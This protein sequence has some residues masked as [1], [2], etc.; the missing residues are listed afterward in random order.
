MFAL[1]AIHHVAILTDSAS[2]VTCK[3]FYTRILG[4]GIVAE[5]YREERDSYKLDLTVNGQYQ[6]VYF[7]QRS[8]P[9]AI[10]LLE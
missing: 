9:S 7:L 2:Y 4:C 1:K 3:D 10:I 8:V 6:I 5:T